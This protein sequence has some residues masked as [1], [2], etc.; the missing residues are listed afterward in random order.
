M[1]RMTLDEARAHI[2]ENGGKV[3]YHNTHKV[4][5]LLSQF[6]MAYIDPIA[7][8]ELGTCVD[9][10][11]APATA[12]MISPDK[13]VCREC[14]SHYIHPNQEHARRQWVALAE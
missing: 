13:T 9:C 2:K 7:I 8:V 6:D 1:K 4:S 3:V 10:N 14:Q 11:E 12:A 5:Y